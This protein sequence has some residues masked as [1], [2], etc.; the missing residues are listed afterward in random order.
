[1]KSYT[2]KDVCRGQDIKKRIARMYANRRLRQKRGL[3]PK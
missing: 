1:M 3:L 2:M